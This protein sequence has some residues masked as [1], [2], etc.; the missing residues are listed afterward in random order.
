MLESNSGSHDIRKSKKE[1]KPKMIVESL[2]LE[3]SPKIP[4]QVGGISG[5]NLI[6]SKEQTSGTERKDS[7]SEKV[8]NIKNFFEFS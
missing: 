6:F 2:L 4:L 1:K 3:D 5:V 8:K 7:L